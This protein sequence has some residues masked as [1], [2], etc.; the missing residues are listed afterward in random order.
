MNGKKKFEFKPIH[1]AFLLTVLCHT[2]VI[3]A[4]SIY[5]TQTPKTER[6]R[7]IAQV[8]FVD[9][10]KMPAPRV[11][12]PKKLGLK[13]PK[14][15]PSRVNTHIPTP[16][17]MSANPG[18]VGRPGR[19]GRPGTPGG[20]GRAG[21]RTHIDPDVPDLGGDLFGV[22]GYPVGH[23]SGI[24]NK[25][26][27]GSGFGQ[28]D[29][30]GDGNGGDGGEGGEGGEGGDGG[31][32]NYGGLPY[33]ITCESSDGGVEPEIMK[34]PE[35]YVRL[36]FINVSSEV[37]SMKV[38]GQGESVIYSNSWLNVMPGEERSAEFR[39]EPGRFTVSIF[40]GSDTH[41]RQVQRAIIEV[42]QRLH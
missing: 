37:R 3:F 6:M 13:A 21:L 35:G 40:S 1:A 2:L 31:D 22:G 42:Y 5:A 30:V 4:L 25:K 33:T 11:Q 7:I 32:M 23:G 19:P 27:T 12:P 8:D 14:I 10:I 28:G 41:G 36:S 16:G 9:S 20:S 15:L 39:L 24:G 18:K 29:G 17:R 34:A 38:E 26:G